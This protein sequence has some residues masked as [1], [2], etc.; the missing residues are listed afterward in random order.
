MEFIVNW[1]SFTAQIFM[2]SNFYGLEYFFI[3]KEFL[4]IIIFKQMIDCNFLASFYLYIVKINYY[5][6]IIIIIIIIITNNNNNNNNNKR[7]YCIFFILYC[8]YQRQ[9]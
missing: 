7:V 9:S 2:K 1:I 3:L 5:L 6:F 4:Y 8:F